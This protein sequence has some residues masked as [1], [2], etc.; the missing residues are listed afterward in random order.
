MLASSQIGQIVK[1]P[2]V[3]VRPV[4]AIWDGRTTRLSNTEGR[5]ERDAF[6]DA[7]RDGRWE[8]VFAQLDRAP[9]LVNSWRPG[10]P[11]WYT[12]VHQAAWHGADLSVVRR[13]LTYG[14]WLTMRSARGD[15]PLDIALRGGHTHLT[16]SLLPVVHHPLPT[17]LHTVL[18]R[19]LHE[20]IRMVAGNYADDMRLP[21]LDVLTELARP[22]VNLGVPGLGASVEVELKG[23]ELEVLT[24]SRFVEGSE[25]TRRISA[26]GTE[27]I[28]SGAF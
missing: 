13:L 1:K 2:A 5:A 25:E 18:Q 20:V 21:E 9:E 14:A 22:R 19:R 6:A 3:M 26:K 27:L 23:D 28:S 15:R 7:A 17:D 16:G 8:D 24:W 11:S 4:M 12:P 10:G